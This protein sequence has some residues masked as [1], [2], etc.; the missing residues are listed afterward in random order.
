MDEPIFCP[1]CM[2]DMLT[3][4]V[5]PSINNYHCLNCQK[6]FLLKEIDKP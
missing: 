2:Q 3:K 1:Y 4:V 6:Y 5:E